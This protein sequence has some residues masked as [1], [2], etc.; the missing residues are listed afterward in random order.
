MPDLVNNLVS[1]NSISSVFLTEIKNKFHIEIVAKRVKLYLKEIAIISYLILLTFSF[2]HFDFFTS[3]Y[4]AISLIT[5]FYNFKFGVEISKSQYFNDFKYTSLA[6]IIYN[7]G[8][9]IGVLL[10]VFN[11][12]FTALLILFFSYLRFYLAYKRYNKIHSFTNSNIDLQ[13]IKL[14]SRKNFF[15]ALTSTSVITLA[16]MLDKLIAFNVGDGILSLFNYAE[17]IYILPLSL[18]LV[19]VF[20]AN[21][22]ILTKLWNQNK[23]LEYKSH[24]QKVIFLALI[25]SL[26][27]FIFF[28]T[29]GDF[30]INFI[31]N[32]SEIN[33]TQIQLIVNYFNILVYGLIPYVIIIWFI[34]VFL[35]R[36]LY[37]DL[38]ILSIIMFLIKIVYLLVITNQ[39][40]T[41]EKILIYNFLWLTLSSLILLSYYIFKI[42]N[43]LKT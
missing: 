43:N 21:Y 34:N 8:S 22:P 28:M 40:I 11:L 25:I 30:V 18:V 1:G 29:L 33:E 7:T 23:I 13:N 6:N 4:I 15:V 32:F 41:F 2:L 35:I 5:I 26:I 38:F 42:K 12:Y 17:K 20:S 39:I 3:T 27:I 24:V 36:K 14:I 10:A 9:I 37:I 16:P 19:P 31:F